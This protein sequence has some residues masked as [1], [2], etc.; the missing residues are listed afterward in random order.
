MRKMFV[1]AFLILT[2]TGF[3]A[4]QI[5]TSGNVFFGYS[6]YN[7][8]VS[9]LNRTNMNGWEA[10]VE[11][12]IF[13]FIGIVADFDSHYGSQS[14]IVPPPLACPVS[15]PNCGVT[16]NANFSENNYLFGPRVSVSVGKIRPFAEALFGSGHIHVNGFSSDTSFATAVGGGLDYKIL[17]IL[18]W[19]VQGDYVHTSLLNSHQNNVRISTGIV[20]RF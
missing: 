13:P 4:A 15:I 19:R 12:K 14:G 7:S 5:P 17:R 20:V 11:G 9:A 8:D 10:S 18:A 16:F 1:T 6:Y 3:A 2:I